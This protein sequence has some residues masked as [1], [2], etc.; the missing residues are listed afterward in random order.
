MSVYLNIKNLNQKTIL[1]SE[2]KTILQSVAENYIDW[3]Q[4]CGGKGRC[5]TCKMVV[6]QGQELLNSLTEVELKFRS[7]NRLADNERL[8]CQTKVLSEFVEGVIYITIPKNYQLPHI[9]YND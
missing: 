4:S 6:E 7:L 8:A 1:I 5:T 9:Y 2:K 3:M